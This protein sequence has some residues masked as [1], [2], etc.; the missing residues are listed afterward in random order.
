MHARMIQSLALSFIVGVP[1]VLG[2][3]SLPVNSR[4]ETPKIEVTPLHGS[5]IIITG[6]QLLGARSHRINIY[7]N[8]QLELHTVVRKESFRLPLADLEAGDTIRLSILN[9][10]GPG[11]HR[12]IEFT[13]LGSST[14][15]SNDRLAN[16]SLSRRPVPGIGISMR[17]P[18]GSVVIR[19]RGFHQA[20]R[21]L[22]FVN[23]RQQATIQVGPNGTLHR[24]LLGISNNDRV[25]VVIRHYH[26]Q[27]KHL[28]RTFQASDRPNASWLLLGG[29]AVLAIIGGIAGVFSG[30]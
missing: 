8:D 14:S 22:I 28:V 17:S 1:A 25:R 18:E 24:R 6:R 23:D 13:A 27:G 20:Y 3:T 30:S 5:R 12:D 11:L 2:D 4:Q 10:A 29:M 15:S 19:G 9:D 21:V 16:D 7:V 26:G